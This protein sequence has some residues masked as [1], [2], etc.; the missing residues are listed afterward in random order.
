[1]AGLFGAA[2]L[3]VGW[4]LGWPLVID[5]DDPDFNPMILIFGLF[6]AFTAGNIVQALRWQSR[7]RRYGASQIDID[8]RPPIALGTA[9]SGRVRTR[10]PVQATGDFRLVL[11]CFD[12]HERRNTSSSSSTSPY[13]S[14]AFP[15]WKAECTLPAATDTTKGLPFRFDLPASVG[16]RPAPAIRPAGSPYFR[17]SISIN[18][19]GLRRIFTRNVPPVARYWTL[20]VTAP[21]PGPD[22]RAEFTVPLADH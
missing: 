15:V 6:A 17:G 20:V 2:T 4:M 19:P 10:Q 11:T 9:F 3:W 22:Y 21:M 13:K 5:I 16:E 7:G 12:V 8:G 1:M 18:V 14:E